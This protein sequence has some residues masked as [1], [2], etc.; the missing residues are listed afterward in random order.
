MQAEG[1]LSDGRPE[2]TELLENA[3]TAGVPIT[4]DVERAMVSSMDIPWVSSQIFN[5]LLQIT[6][7]SV[8]ERLALQVGKGHGLE[9]WRLIH[10]E[11]RSKAPQVM[12]TYRVAFE[13]PVKCKTETEVR[14]RLAQWMHYG[15][16]YELHSGFKFA[17]QQKIWALRKFLPDNMAQQVETQSDWGGEI[18][19]RVPG[20]GK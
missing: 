4:R 8:M 12:E 11:W 20:V 7:G 10:A 3:I 2:I 18:L 13:N 6:A 9:V 14:T 19:R 16:E 1:F 5:G 15:K 17:E